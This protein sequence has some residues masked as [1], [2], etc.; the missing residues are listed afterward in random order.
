MPQNVAGCGLSV[1]CGQSPGPTVL[2]KTD[3][4]FSNSLGCMGLHGLLCTL[5]QPLGTRVHLSQ[6]DASCSHKPTLALAL[7]LLSL[8]E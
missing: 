7:S 6:E 5:S 2:E 3:S 4:S 8:P 1:E